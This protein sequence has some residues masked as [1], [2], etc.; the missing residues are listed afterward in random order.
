MTVL[1]YWILVT[2]TL[3]AEKAN[4]VTVL[5]KVR[6]RYASYASYDMHGMIQ[7]EANDGYYEGGTR[8]FWGIDTPVIRSAGIV[9]R[10]QMTT[11]PGSI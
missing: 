7:M 10:P 3:N 1:R 11:Y 5:S 9:T 2:T 8:H 6:Y 4:L